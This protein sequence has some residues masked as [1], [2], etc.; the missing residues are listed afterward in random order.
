VLRKTC[1]WLLIL[2]G[3]GWANFLNDALL[4]SFSVSAMGRG[5]AEIAAPNAS[6]SLISNP[7]GLAQSGTGLNYNNLDYFAGAPQQFNST[8]YH[9]PS[10]GIGTW[11]FQ[12]NSNIMNTFGVGV[13]KRSQ[14]GVDWGVSYRNNSTKGLAKNTPF[15]VGDLGVLLHINRS[16]D[17]GVVGKNL[18]A[19]KSVDIFPT[20]KSGA[21]FKNQGSSF[22]F[23]TDI[24]QK[25]HNNHGPDVALS[26]GMD[27]ALT[28][29][30]LVRFGANDTHYALGASFDL[31][32]FSFDYAYQ[33]PK[34]NKSH[35]MT[36]WGVRFGK[37]ERSNDFRKKYALFKQNSFAFININ[38]SLTGGYS[39]ISLLG[40]KKI[41]A[42]D[43]I[44][45]I[46][47]A[48]NDPDCKG[49]LL[50]IESIDGGLVN[51]ALVQEVRN[52]LLKAKE[53]G[54]VVIVYLDGWSPMASYYLGSVGDLVVMPP[55]GA[56]HQLGV[57][58]DVLK[59]DDLL[60][61]FGI[62]Y[63]SITSGKHKS[64]TSPLTKKMSLSQKELIQGSLENVLSQ[65]KTEINRSRNRTLNRDIYD[66]RIMSAETAKSLGL[67]DRIAFWSDIP[68]VLKEMRP[69]ASITNIEAYID[70]K[71]L[72][73]LWPE[74]NKIA[75][76]EINGTI[77]NGKNRSDV[78]FG[79][80][81]TGADDIDFIFDKLSKDPFIKGVILRINSPGGSVLAADQMLNA[82]IKFK[83]KS[84][85]PVYAS[86]GTVAASGG[87][88]VALGSDQIFANGATLTGS[89]GVVSGFLNFYEFGK[90]WGITSQQLSTGKYMD[91]FSSTR[92]LSKD[93]ESM[94]AAHQDESFRHF[95]SKVQKSRKLTDDELHAVAQGQLMTGEEA[96]S[97][98]LV[99]ELGSY[100]DAVDA[101]STKLKINNPSIVVVGRPVTMPQ[102]NLLKF[103]IN[104]PGM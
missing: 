78:L 55:L 59:F 88:Y 14:N 20:F 103:L 60:E 31:F 25:N 86:M 95:Q 72:N 43:L 48:N 77:A 16:I 52:E 61:R 26:Y 80:V 79:G 71:S 7:A 57:Q 29:E 101:M 3:A 28:P 53:R 27:I 76:V 21:V 65:L 12:Q 87:Y 19:P 49:Y 30:F 90:E 9:R 24:E 4:T 62:K 47:N 64:A 54:K 15:W 94:I 13:A 42:D 22:K 33:R 85:K 104:P 69:D 23:F 36:A 56:I 18:I 34:T 81:Q 99:D 100:I 98:G 32:S 58:L 92:P 10:F 5:G 41:G 93:T 1:F 66:G 82:I 91:A 37:S 83:S 46:D 89:I 39:S 45:L 6:D 97:L 50:R 70:N 2:A 11:V 73:F 63:H 8:I 68:N 84:N 96:K 74:T 75:I 67:I 44:Q 102:F 17:I 51:I 35:S 40:G 38:G